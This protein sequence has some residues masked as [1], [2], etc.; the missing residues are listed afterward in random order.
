MFDINDFDETLPGPWEWDVKRLAASFEIAGRDRGFSSATRREVVLA[1]AAEYRARLK[2]TAAMGN[3]DVWYS[4]IEFGEL[5]NQLQALNRK[6]AAKARANLAKARTRDSM[7][8]YAKLTEVVDGER[9]IIA[10]PPLVVP[11]EDLLRAGGERDE[12]EGEIR[13]IIRAYRHTLQADRRHLLESSTTSTSLASWSASGV[14]VHAP[15]FC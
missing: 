3:L 12:I 11:I 5:L 6:K 8:A 13:D 10:D 9:R 1:T 15:G 4:H 14:S 2:Q 7:Q